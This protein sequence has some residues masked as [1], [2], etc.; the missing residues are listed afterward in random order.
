MKLADLSLLLHILD[1]DGE[2]FAVLGT[3]N[4]KKIEY[5]DL[6][7]VLIDAVTATEDARFFEHHGIDFRRTGGAIVANIQ[8]W[9]WFRRCKYDYAS[10]GEKIFFSPE[11]KIKIKVQEQWLA[12]HLERKYLERRNFRNVF[13]YN[14]LR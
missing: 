6:P 14:I 4:R 12:F 8:R 5:E 1:K 3:D 2:K 11:K 10:S 13:K 7:Q 9:I